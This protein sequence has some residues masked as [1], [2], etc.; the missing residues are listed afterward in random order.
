MLWIVAYLVVALTVS[1]LIGFFDGDDEVFAGM[2]G[3]FWLP[4]LSVGLVISPFY[5]VAKWAKRLS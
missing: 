5:T 3:L 4:L 1:F 2:V